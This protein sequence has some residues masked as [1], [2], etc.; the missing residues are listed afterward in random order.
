MKSGTVASKTQALRIGIVTIIAMVSPLIQ[1]CRTSAP[2]PSSDP[3]EAWDSQRERLI[4]EASARSVE[5][6]V[7]QLES[8]DAMERLAAYI[9]LR[10]RSPEEALP[11]FMAAL[12]VNN[13]HA[14]E[15]YPQIVESWGAEAVP[16]LM[17]VLADSSLLVEEGSPRA[18]YLGWD[19][20]EGLRSIGPEA[21]D[22]VPLLL[23]KLAEPHSEMLNSADVTEALEAIGDGRDEV[24]GALLGALEDEGIDRRV[25]ACYALGELA[26]PDDEVVISR[27]VEYVEE[28]ESNPRIVLWF[29]V[30]PAR[31]AL[32]KL[33]Y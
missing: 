32:Y 18:D 9:A 8:E 30:I 1:G 24:I 20:I 7:A 16:F 14:W 4:D 17:E 11:V 5:Q 33:G 10:D 12:D 31:C 6:L 25:G 26:S 22:A 23:Q 13:G 21:I 15:A 28:L 2:G 29:F 19:A 3:I 27:L